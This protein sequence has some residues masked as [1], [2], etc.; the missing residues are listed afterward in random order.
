MNRDKPL[1]SFHFLIRTT[2]PHRNGLRLFLAGL[3]LREG[4]Q[5]GELKYIFCDDKYLLDLNRTFLKHNFY[6]DILSFPSLQDE[7][8]KVSGEIY[9][10]VDRVRENAVDLG[11]SF[12]QEIHRVIFHGALHLCHYKDKTKKE[13]DQMRSK[14]DEYLKRYLK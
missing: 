14:E 1:V 7:N 8:K 10:S 5:L 6:T 9:I 12:K 2:L 13:Q 4:Q 11:T 3:F